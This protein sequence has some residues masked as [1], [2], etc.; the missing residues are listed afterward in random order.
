[1]NRSVWALSFVML[2]VVAGGLVIATNPRSLSPDLDFAQSSANLYLDGQTLSDGNAAQAERSE[3][4]GG[5]QD[6]AA[7]LPPA[8]RGHLEKLMAATPGEGPA[9]SAAEWRFRT[10]AYPAKGYFNR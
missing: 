7:N 4:V 10:R 1:M 9:G 8:L 3:S 5:D 6:A 2:V